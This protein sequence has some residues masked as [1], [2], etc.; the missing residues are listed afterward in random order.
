MST[1]DDKIEKFT[2]HMLR[3][4]R[5]LTSAQL[6]LMNAQRY[7]NGTTEDDRTWELLWGNLR[8]VMSLG[9]VIRASVM[10]S[11]APETIEVETLESAAP[12]V[13]L[14]PEESKEFRPLREAVDNAMRCAEQM[15][16]STGDAFERLIYAGHGESDCAQTVSMVR[17]YGRA[18]QS[19]LETV[20]SELEPARTVVTN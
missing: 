6:D 20:Q 17:L 7:S 11:G 3:A 12:P 9:G 1:T 4:L 18:A 15:S 5:A 14:V 10:N 19:L 8:S 13:P 2:S 16:R